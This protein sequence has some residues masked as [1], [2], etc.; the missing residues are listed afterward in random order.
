[1]HALLE[2]AQGVKNVEAIAGASPRMHGMSLGPAD[3]AAS[4]KMKTTRVGGGHPFYGVLADPSED[5]GRLAASTSRISGTTRS[6][7]DGRCLQ[8]TRPRRLLRPLRRH[9]GRSGLR[10]AVPER[11]PDGMF[12]VPGRWRPTRSRLPSGYSARTSTKYCSRS[13]SSRRCLTASG[14]A[15]IDGKMQDDATWKQAKRYGRSCKRLVAQER[16]RTSPRR[17]TCETCRWMSKTRVRVTIFEDFR[18][19]QEIRHATRHA[20]IT[21]GDV[22]VYQGLVRSAI[23]ALFCGH[24]CVGRWASS[25]RRSIACLLFTSC[26]A[27]NGARRVTQ[28]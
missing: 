1:M 2:T 20:P 22:A 8:C 12:R 3:L 26:S 16:T 5:A 25:A 10:G 4:R 27:E 24:I 7:K 18:V 14:V 13:A 23:R 11:F 15:M 17:T 28:R 19:G 21:E 9:Q 6:R